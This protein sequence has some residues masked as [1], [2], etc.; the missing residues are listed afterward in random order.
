LI[1]KVRPN[2]RSLGQLAATR[3][4]LTSEHAP[5]LDAASAVTP[6]Y[7]YCHTGT[8]HW[9]FRGPDRTAAVKVNGRFTT[10]TIEGVHQTSLGGLGTALLSNWMAGEGLASGALEEARLSDAAP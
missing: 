3:V 2:L 7:L 5:R 9:S 10:S 6:V 1:G 8:T 4:V